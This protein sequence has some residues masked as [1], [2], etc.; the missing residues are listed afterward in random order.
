M[1]KIS[2]RYWQSPLGEMIIG[3]YKGQI[4]LAD[5]L[6]S[7]KRQQT[8]KRIC[9]WL[10]AEYHQES[11]PAIQSVISQLEEYFKGIRRSFDLPLLMAGT[12]F[13]KQAWD[14][15]LKIPYG[16]TISYGEQARRIG[17][18]KAV[19][20]VA[21]ANSCNPICIIV[22]CHRVIGANHTLTGYAGGLDIKASLLEIEGIWPRLD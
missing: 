18:P 17:R 2:V 9:Q 21:N 12:E 10:N 16:T 6:S 5:W 15:L 11:T 19:R 4:C 20:A 13:Q 8:D 1:D 14:A 7:P 22:P 3:D